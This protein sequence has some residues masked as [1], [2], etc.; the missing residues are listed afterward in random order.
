MDPR[1]R[2]EGMNRSRLEGA[3]DAQSADSRL[4]IG[5]FSCGSM[6]RRST[7]DASFQTKRLAHRMKWFMPK[8]SLRDVADAPLWLPRLEE[9]RAAGV[10][11]RVA[12]EAIAK[13]EAVIAKSKQV[14]ASLLHNLLTRGLDEHGRLRDP[15]AHPKN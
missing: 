11:L 9:Q 7:C 10:V 4:R 1:T 8:L 15:L 14:R 12:D 13:M 5:V 6:P 3:K 2:R